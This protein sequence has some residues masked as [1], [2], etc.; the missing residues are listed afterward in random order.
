MKTLRTITISFLSI[1]FLFG[2]TL[3][4]IG[5]FKPKPGGISVTTSPASSIYINGSLVGKTPYEGTFK[6]GAVT[7][8]LV[9][10]DS[11]KNYVPFETRLTL[12]SGIKTVVR[13]EFAET[14]EASSGDVIFFEKT[15][16][17][18][19]GLVIISNPE[20]AQTAIDG[21]PRGFAPYKTSTITQGEHQVTIKAP[22]YLDRILTIR[23]IAGYR[24]TV[25]AKLAK[26]KEE[27]KAEKTEKKTFVEILPTPT[28]FL[29]VRTEPGGGSEIDQVKPGAKYPFL[30]ENEDGTWYKIQLEAPA[31]GLPEGRSGWVSSEFAKKIEEDIQIVPVETPL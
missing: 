19:V 1:I 28:G 2:T 24:L 29:R 26:I 3:F 10:E 31:P 14:E 18:E 9:P 27:V 15:G 13:R 21:V 17:R 30:E 5:Y 6:A 11:S 20:N 23:T 16:R 22:G 8:K 25:F 12:V 4:L 7:L